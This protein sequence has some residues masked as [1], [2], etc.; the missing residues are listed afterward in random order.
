MRLLYTACNTQDN[1]RLSRV[2]Q[3]FEQ[4]KRQGKLS[5]AEQDAFQA[6]LDLAKAGEWK[7]AEQASFRFSQDQ[8]R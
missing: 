8:V 3:E 5:S 6:I 4:A 2:E 1:K 7:R